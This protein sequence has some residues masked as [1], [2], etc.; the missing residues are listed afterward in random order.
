MYS[1]EDFT[2]ENVQMSF[3]EVRFIFVHHRPLLTEFV[4]INTPIFLSD[5]QTQHCYQLLGGA[6]NSDLNKNVVVNNQYNM[7]I[8]VKMIVLPVYLKLFIGFSVT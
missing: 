5:A 8:V 4:T 2:L 7:L 6:P 1:V 3:G